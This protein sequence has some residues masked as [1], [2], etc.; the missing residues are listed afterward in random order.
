MR[1]CKHSHAIGCTPHGGGV[2]RSTH[3]VLSCSL[4]IVVLHFALT[5]THTHTLTRA[6]HLSDAYR[7]PHKL[8]TPFK[9]GE[10]RHIHC[11]HQHAASSVTLKT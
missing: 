2:G 11:N 6:F 10:L 7:H 3:R 8:K 1:A 9:K 4:P 5:H